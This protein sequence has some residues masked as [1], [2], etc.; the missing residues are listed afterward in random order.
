MNTP[1]LH[2][3]TSMVGKFVILNGTSDNGWAIYTEAKQPILYATYEDAEAVV[4]RFPAGVHGALILQV[5][6]EYKR[7]HHFVP[8]K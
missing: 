6:G 5:S 7:A 2:T 4:N 8:V 1:T 3:T